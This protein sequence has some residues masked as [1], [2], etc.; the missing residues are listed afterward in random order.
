MPQRPALVAAVSPGLRPLPVV[1]LTPCGP[2]LKQPSAAA[3][4]YK[5]PAFRRRGPH[6]CEAGGTEE[7]PARGRLVRGEP[8]GSHRPQ[9]LA[10]SLKPE[11]EEKA[12]HTKSLRL[13]LAGDADPEWAAAAMLILPERAMEEVILKAREVEDKVRARLRSSHRT[14]FYSWCRAGSDGS[15]RA[16]F[17]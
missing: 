12:R 14:G 1:M 10:W 8:H 4:A 11:S 17:R 7:G 6:D 5:A 15:M 9:A 13:A 2:C 3:T 16:L